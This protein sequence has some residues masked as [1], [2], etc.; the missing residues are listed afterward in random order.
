MDLIRILPWKPLDSWR[1]FPHSSPLLIFGG[2]ALALLLGID[3]GGTY[4]DA[5]L[6][7]TAKGLLESAK[8]LTTHHDLTI[9]I[10]GAVDAV[11]GDHAGQIALVSVSTTLA[12][13]AI[14]EG[15]GSP[16]ALVLIG[17]ARDD[18]E[19]PDI[20]RAM[21]GDPLIT[22][23]G[24]HDALGEEAAT[25]DLDHLRSEAARVAPRVSAFA[26]SSMFSVRNP[27]HEIA[28]RDMLRRKTGLPVS[29]GHNLSSELDAPRRALTALL[30]AKL[31]SLIQ[32]LVVTVTSLM[33]ERGIRAPVMAVKGDGSLIDAATALA[34][35]VETILS[36]PAASV[37]GAHHLSGLDEAF[38]SDIGG[39]TTDIALVHGGRPQ[40][41][42]GGARVGGYRTMVRAVASYTSG[43]GG[44]SEIRLDDRGRLTVGPRRAVPLALLASR[45]PKVVEFLE[46]QIERPWPEEWDAVFV[47]RLRQ[48]D[49]E[50]AGLSRPQRALWEALSE[51]PVPMADLYRDRSPK[52]SL[53]AL[54]DRNLIITSRFTPSDAAHV[55]D[56]H[57]SWNGQ[58]SELA[59]RLWLRWWAMSGHEAPDDPR[60]FARLVVNATITGSVRA[61]L[62][63]AMEM[64]HG[65]P[66]PAGRAANALL[67]AALEG[68]D[69][70]LFDIGVRFRH[71]VV[72]VGAPAATYYPQMAS[73]LQ[74]GIVVPPHAEVCNAVGAVAGGV[75]Q[76]VDGLLTA[77]HSGTFRC[78]LPEGIAD[79][80]DLELA[81][82]HARETLERLARQSAEKIGAD[83]ITVRL[84]R[85]DEIVRCKDGSMLFIESRLS[86]VAAGR[87][88]LGT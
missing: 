35:P 66:L 34:T 53:E 51:G 18:C 19:R 50:P 79:F 40:L 5:V 6:F 86:A 84:E 87:P 44:D 46:Q 7:D 45:H 25:L 43:L 30:N 57:D 75:V 74:T 48:L 13:N 39:T 61:L 42:P 55:L 33:A 52:L 47:L 67:E 38:I 2:S 83:D 26:V 16:A 4:T 12:T 71:P 63:A 60:A 10:A 88:A 82:H 27:E 11:I 78:H 68:R 80:E 3:T 62:Q 70:G 77:P 22:G 76:R 49:T 56:I 14:V 8:A 28:V 64:E 73:R 21:A 24:G 20:V 36:G 41:D 58:A 15:R 72:G 85:K 29:C 54:S 59:A 81:A 31:I 17:H 23:T 9:G 69:G 1:R 37:I 65:L 32:E